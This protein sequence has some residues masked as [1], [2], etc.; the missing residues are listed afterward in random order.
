MIK[1]LHFKSLLLLA[2]M[3][4]GVGS[5]WGTTT[6]KLTKVT[7]V[8]AGNKYVFVRNDRALGNNVSSSALQTTTFSTSGLTGTEAYVWTL[9]AKDDG[10]YLKNVSRTENQYL[11]NSSSTA[12]SF[13]AKN[14][15]WTITFTDDVALISNKSNSNRFLGE[16]QTDSKKYKAY[17]TDNLE[18]YGHDFTVYELEEGAEGVATPAFSLVNGAVEKG[19]K[20]TITSA[21]EGA[22]IYYTTDDS[23]PTSGSTLYSDEIT[24]NS[25]VT[26]KA[27]AIK[28][29]N[30]SDV[31]SAEYTIK[32]VATP[33]FSVAAGEVIPGTTVTLSTTTKDA[34]IHYTIDGT[35]P[36]ESSSTYSEAIT[37]SEA[38][39]IKAIASKTNWDD[40]DIASVEYTVTPTLENIAALTAKNTAGTYLVTL[41]NA[42]V[43]FASGKYAYIKDESG[44]ILYFKDGH[45]L[46]AGDVLNGT[47]EVTYK[48]YNS[49]PQITNLSKVTTT[50]GEAAEPTS[51]AASEWNY[52]FEN[53]LSQYLQITGATVTKDGS[54]YYISLGDDKVQLYKVGEAMNLDLTKTY[55]ITGFPT[56]Y[57]TT[58][59]ILIFSD[60]EVEIGAE[61]TIISS[62]TALKGFTYV[63]G[64]GPSATKTISVS[65]ENLTE[66]ITLSLG[67][68]SNYEM[69]LAENDNYGNSLTLTQTEGSVVETTIYVRLK[70]DLAVNASY[71]GTITLTSGSASEI[72]VSLTGSVKAPEAPNMTWD[73][74]TDQTETATEDE[75][76]WTSDYATMAAEKGDATTTTNNYYP[77]TTGKT[78]TSTRFY[79]GSTLTITPINNYSIGS[80]VFEATSTSYATALSNSTWTNATAAANDKIVTVTPTDGTAA[81][82]AAIG[83][84]CG[85]TSVIVYYQPTSV[86]VTIPTALYTT[87]ASFYAIDFSGT[88]VTAYTAK[89]EG[90]VVRLTP[91]SDNI[92]PANTG[93]I[94]GAAVAGDYVG[95][96]TTGGT[97]SDN[98]LV[99]AVTVTKVNYSANSKFNYILQDGVFKKATGAKLNAGKAYLS[100]TYDVTTSGTREL[101]LVI[102]N[103][104][105][106]ISSA[107]E[108]PNDGAVYSLSG[109]RVVNP[110]KGLYIVNGKKYVIK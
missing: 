106:G 9:E 109:Q 74:S 1:K 94:L 48:L 3:L 16:T 92:V 30:S 62:S 107:T 51:L 23:K 95:N 81:I 108:Q 56:L 58:K 14:S 19:T 102:N 28:D 70:E 96:A 54:K 15:I 79:G 35:D 18:S 57:N 37:I 17:A 43:T 42:V 91:V 98:E 26:I 55:T 40:S 25:A 77:G 80:V 86:N 93:V 5:A 33:A 60:P 67:E 2:V 82:S 7:S 103:E 41:S 38:M 8:S 61:P 71:S 13:G 47:A 44:A 52:T 53:V 84:T 87:F 39:T 24:I 72:T 83:A 12:V 32:K 21:T 97:V 75:M 4:L 76:T 6:Y 89:T 73:L 34:T 68:A 49:N 11:N 59:E 31:A 63:V 90:D 65:G 100:T 66:D 20:V 10:F 101:K 69:S 104:T 110:A 46:T 85:F 105:T 78:Y 50:S 27:I 64:D 99:A 88:G 36:T 22:N 29:G 45:G